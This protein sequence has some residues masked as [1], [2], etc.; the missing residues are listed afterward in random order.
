MVG[1]GRVEK[2]GGVRGS[3]ASRRMPNPRLKNWLKTQTWLIDGLGC[4]AQAQ[5]IY[6]LCSCLLL[7]LRKWSDCITA[8]RLITARLGWSMAFAC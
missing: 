3:E 5:C 7:A 4:G 1:E 6:A 2:G 8:A